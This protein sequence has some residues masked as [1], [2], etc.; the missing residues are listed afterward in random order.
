MTPGPIC[1]VEVAEGAQGDHVLVSH[2]LNRAQEAHVLLYRTI[3][4]GPSGL[5]RVERETLAVA[6]SAA[7]DCH[8]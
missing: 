1:W 3:L 7:N 5:S 8:Y 2:S 6:V 4:F